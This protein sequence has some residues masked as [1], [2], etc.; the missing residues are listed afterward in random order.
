ML[1]A[2]YRP[3][4]G[5]ASPRDAVGGSSLAARARTRERGMSRGFSASRRVRRTVTNARAGESRRATVM[6]AF[7]RNARARGLRKCYFMFSTA[8][9]RTSD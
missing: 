4:R 3:E 2:L 5:G 6:R 1:L 9:G 7:G 8:S